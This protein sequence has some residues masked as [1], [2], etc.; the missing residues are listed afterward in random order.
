MIE[1]SVAEDVR[2][3]ACFYIKRQGIAEADLGIWL[4]VI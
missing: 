2:T 3:S 4:S 1:A